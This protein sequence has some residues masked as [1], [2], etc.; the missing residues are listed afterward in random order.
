MKF[1]HKTFL[2]TLTT[3]PGVYQMIDKHGKIIYVGKALN[4]KKRVASYFHRN[5]SELKTAQ[6]VRQI[7]R[8]EIIVTATENE[9]LL[10]ENNLIK[11]YHP[12]YNILFRDDKSYPYI[13]LSH[14]E[15]PCLSLHRG[16]KK[17]NVEYFG[18]YPHS[19]AVHETLNLLQKLFL[20]R[21]CNNNYFKS[22][23][24]PCLQYQIKRCSAPCVKYIDQ[25]TYLNDVQSTRLFLQGKSSVIIEQLQKKMDEAAD[26]LQYELALKYREQIKNLREIQQQQVIDTKAGDLDVLAVITQEN[27][28]CI[29]WL[30]IRQGRIIGGKS[31]VTNI[32]A[33]NSNEEILRAFMMQH[34]INDLHMI[35]E[36]ILLNIKLADMKLLQTILSTKANYTVTIQANGRGKNAEL[37]TMAINSATQAL[38]SHATKNN[39]Y[40]QKFTE[41]QAA[42]NLKHAIKLIECFDVSHT[43]GEATVASCVVFTPQGATKNLYR[44]FNIKGVT[45]GDDYAALK[46]ALTRHYSKTL[47]EQQGHLLI[48]DGGKGQLKQAREVLCELNI[49]H[50]TLLS[51]AKGESRKPG[52]ETIYLGAHAQLIELEKNGAALHLIQEIRDEAH[53]FAIESHRKQARKNKQTSILEGIE[54][55]AATRRKKLLRSFGGLQGLSQASVQEIAKTGSISKTLAQRVYDKLHG[56]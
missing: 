1:D 42:L 46:Q 31:F 48:I 50:I 45:A 27:L 38:A 3:R 43:M 2:K 6:M 55:I 17:P 8:I 7:S 28:A 40:Q 39:L 21:S 24:R 13:A 14:D 32:Q 33:G 29:Q 11:Q 37:I 44:R 26:H 49:E 4:L 56:K 35:P 25:A 22:R 20:I 47:V 12:K 10:L 36:R 15:Y 30:M 19:G 16:A 41:L 54:G 5:I 9:A 23:S 34:Y 52:L 18:P 51:V 53:R